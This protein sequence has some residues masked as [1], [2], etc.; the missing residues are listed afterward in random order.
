MGKKDKALALG[1]A[2]PGRAPQSVGEAQLAG[3][4][5]IKSEETP[6]L[7][8][9]SWPLLLKNFDR[10]NVRLLRLRP[11]SRRPVGRRRGLTAARQG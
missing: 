7:D 4:F 5:A 11:A 8:A 9:S 10:L 6:P 2:G 3:D 1:D